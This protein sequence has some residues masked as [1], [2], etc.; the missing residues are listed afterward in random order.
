M[1]LSIEEDYEDLDP[2]E[3]VEAVMSSDDRF[4]VER[5]D[6]GDLQFHFQ[7]LDP[8]IF[9]HVAWR[10]ELPAMLFTVALAD[11][12]PQERL[13]DAQRLAAII[14][15]HLWLGHFDVWSEDGAIVFRH[16]I[17]MI[18]RAEL[19]EGEVHAMMAATLDAAERF[20]P[21]F[22]WMIVAGR[23]PEEASELA[24]FDVAGEA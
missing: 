18:G 11:K 9:G 12:A 7:G 8:D 1:E 24:L 17:P 15:E 16:A 4:L 21:A 6:D 14:N 10:Q 5:T 13:H 22:N 3:L 20:A 2:V 19:C 23:T